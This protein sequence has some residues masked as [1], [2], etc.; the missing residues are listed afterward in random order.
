MNKQLEYFI[1]ARDK[2]YLFVF[3]DILAY[4]SNVRVKNTEGTIH[5]FISDII[6]IEENYVPEALNRV[7]NKQGLISKVNTL[8]FSD[9][10]CLYWEI[11]DYEEVENNINKEEFKILFDDVVDFI[12]DIQNQALNAN[13]LFRGAF[14]IGRHYK[15]NNVTVSE[16]LVKAH[17]VEGYTIKGPR[18]GIDLTQDN[19]FLTETEFVQGLVDSKRMKREDNILY[20]DYLQMF[21]RINTGDPLNK[22]LEKITIENNREAYYSNMSLIERDSFIKQNKKPSIFKKYEWLKEYHNEKCK[23]LGYP[24]L[25]IE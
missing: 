23:E 20:I 22:E 6:S 2:K 3:L 16:A 9:S 13:I 18:I 14:S 10:F 21:T 12:C 19:E 25:C 8:I 17:D 4:S 11:G 5:E 15:Y 1:E 24:Y 7:K